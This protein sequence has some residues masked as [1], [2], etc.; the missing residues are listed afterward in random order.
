MR[1]EGEQSLNGPLCWVQWMNS[2]DLRSVS[3]SKV[4][5][6]KMNESCVMTRS[7]DLKHTPL[8]QRNQLS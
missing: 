4:V 8:L 2:C 6:I 3:D 7:I 1:D 5:W